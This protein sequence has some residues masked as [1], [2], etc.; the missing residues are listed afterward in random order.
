MNKAF[1]LR[2]F[3]MQRLFNLSKITKFTKK[4]KKPDFEFNDDIIVY[5]ESSNMVHITAHGID[6]KIN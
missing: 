2:I 6:V 4:G 5:F 1:G 3:L